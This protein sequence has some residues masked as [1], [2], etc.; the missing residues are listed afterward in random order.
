MGGVGVGMQDQ[1]G[2]RTVTLWPFGVLAE[3][4]LWEISSGHPNPVEHGW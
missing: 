4:G 2:E 1:T 3:S